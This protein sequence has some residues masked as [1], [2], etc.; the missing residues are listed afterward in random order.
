MNAS[1][2]YLA[3]LQW[4]AGVLMAGVVIRHTR[5]HGERG[6]APRLVA[7]LGLAL[8]VIA[9]LGLV[10]GGPLL[11]LPSPLPDGEAVR[12]ALLSRIPVLLGF[13]EIAW[14]LVLTAV[15]W[16]AALSAITRRRAAGEE[17]RRLQS[18][19]LSSHGKNR[20]PPQT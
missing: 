15:G 12:A 10:V 13:S 1:L 11:P 2:P 14:V 18:R 19:A 5:A 20:G 16:N 17:L 6:A 8:F 3:A 9:A 7:R 4:L